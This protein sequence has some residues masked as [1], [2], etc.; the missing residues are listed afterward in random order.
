MLD[1]KKENNFDEYLNGHLPNVYNFFGCHKTKV[2]DKECFIFRVYASMAK[3][4]DL[5]GDFKSWDV[6]KA[7]MEKVDYRGQLEL[8]AAMDIGKI[9]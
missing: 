3:E 8:L 6:Y 2:N 5:I 9:N 1:M 7:K 4:W